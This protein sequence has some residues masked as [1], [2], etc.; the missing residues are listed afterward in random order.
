MRGRWLL[1]VLVTVMLG[2]GVVSCAG[3]GGGGGMPPE[4]SRRQVV[5]FVRDSAKRV[6]VEGWG[7]RM[8]TAHADVCSLGGGEKGADYSYDY[9]APRGTDFEGDARRVAEYWRS[10]GMSV[11]VT[12]TTPYPTVYG[13]GGPVLRASFVTAAADDMY[14]LGAV[15][16]C[17]P[18]DRVELNKADQRRRDAGEVLPGDEG[19]P[20]LH[21]P[22]REPQT[23]ATPGPTRPAG[24]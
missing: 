18:G 1:V 11:R 2:G 13:E 22:R 17:I 19:A 21:D 10:L 23:P 24:Q 12:N 4:E 15:M 7:P 3:S 6:P 14:N 5:D 9:W 16:P 20:G 8:G